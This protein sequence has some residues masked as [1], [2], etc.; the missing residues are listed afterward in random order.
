MDEGHADINPAVGVKRVRTGS[1]GHH[2]WTVEEVQQYED[3]HPE[4]SKARLA[5]SLL[6]LTG[7]RASDAIRLG[8]QMER[9]GRLHFT[10]HKDRNRSPKR[11]TIP[12]I[13]ELRAVIDATPSSHLSYLVTEH[14]RP[15]ATAKAFGNRFKSWCRQAGL[16]HC[17]AH[18]LRKA[19]ATIAADRGT[20]AHALMAIY[21]WTTLKQ[22]ELYTREADR[23]TPGRSVHA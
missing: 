12:I 9:D 8:R 19:G 22:A 4:G 16:D 20:P 15:Y 13:P 21:G 5:L 2:T 17:S 3:R 1:Q 10:E 14:G 11:R 7:V 6:L 23:E 18:G